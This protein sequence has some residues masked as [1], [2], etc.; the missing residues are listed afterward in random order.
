M[1]KK[2]LTAHF[3]IL[4][5]LFSPC[6]MAQALPDVVRMVKDIELPRDEMRSLAVDM[7][8]RLPGMPVHIFCQLR[9]CASESYSLKVYD[10]ND[11]A[12]LLIVC[13]QLAL[14][15]DPF[16]ET[17]SLIASAGVVFE[18]LP[19]AGRYTA[20]FAFNMPVDGRVNNKVSFDF[21]TMFSRLT[22][23]VEVSSGSAS[24]LVFSGMTKEKSRCCAI[25]NASAAMPLQSLSL[26]VEDTVNPVLE[27]SRIEVDNLSAEAFLAFPELELRKSGIAVVY[28]A[29]DGF[30]D[31]MSVMSSVVKAIIGRSAI[32]KPEMREQVEKILLQKVDWNN[33]S[34]RDIERSSLLRKLF[35]EDEVR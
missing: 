28:M 19:Q 17:L 10:G 29:P 35:P 30:L 31:T 9:Y 34:S 25:F 27:F 13:D 2:N 1:N 21:K 12:P 24:T 14:I 20:N 5:V 7:H 33:I 6:L 11:G 16:A 18:L 23:N 15:N 22:E 8:M 32:S 26:F 3:L 4:F